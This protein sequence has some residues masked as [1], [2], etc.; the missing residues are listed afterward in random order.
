MSSDRTRVIGIFA[1][2]AVVAGGAGFWFVKIYRPGQ[3]LKEA[4]EEIAGWETRWA[5]ARGCLLGPTPASSKTAEA[6]AIREMMPDPWNGGTC[7]PLI[8]KLTRG[9][10]V[11]S[12]V[13]DVEHAWAELDQ[14]AAKAAAAFA[15][16]VAAPKLDDDPLPDALDALDA[17]RAKLRTA[18]KLPPAESTGKSLP[19]AQV[20]PITDRDEPV[21]ELDLEALPSAHGRIAFGHTPSHVVQV[22]LTAGAAP[23]VARLGPGSRRGVP[24]GGWGAVPGETELKAGAFDVEGAMATPSVVKTAPSKIVLAAVGSL[25]DGVIVSRDDKQLVVSHALAAGKPRKAVNGAS[26]TDVDGR[27]AIVWDDGKVARAQIVKPGD[28]EPEVE[29]DENLSDVC[30]TRDRAWLAGVHYLAFGG[31]KPMFLGPATQGVLIGC[32][33]D[34]AV[35]REGGSPQ[36]YTICS[37]ES[38]RQVASPADAR[39]ASVAV[40]AGK[41][42]ALSPHGNVLG[43]WR[44]DGTK[45]FYA[46]SE[47]ARLA[48]THAWPAMATTDG[49]V[50]D[51]LA[52]GK[53]SM[54]VLRVPAS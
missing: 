23:S 19:T 24:D 44:E 30:L 4:Q 25:A 18:A 40:T 15:T 10:A 27:A 32:N 39:L 7:T 22:T 54:V 8:S 12:G 38:C 49:K 33:L 41:L 35:A 2:V 21:Q 37:G 3:V 13:V 28:D 48:L 5:A 47:P 34:A 42:V 50:I 9:D 53:K 20:V 51:V 31:G 52:R 11:D 17:A 29:L 45:T 14:A 6:L 36:R 1:A 16:H 43:V 46:L 26:S